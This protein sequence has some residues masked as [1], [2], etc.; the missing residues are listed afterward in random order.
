MIKIT[1]NDTQAVSSLQQIARQLESPRRLY[2]ILGESLKK[3]HN[4]RF[5][6]EIDPEGN[7]WQALSDRTLA[8]KRKRGKS[9][10]I[11]RQDGNLADRTAYNIKADGVEFGSSQPYAALHHFGGRAGRRRKVT[12][13]ARPWL[14]VG[15]R[16]EDYLLEKA[17]HHLRQTLRNIR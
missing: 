7:R 3:I 12:I 10:K 4:Q 8:L 5:K 13:P 15:R 9:L 11:L 16:D 14:G 6:Q 2:G 17:R 1:L